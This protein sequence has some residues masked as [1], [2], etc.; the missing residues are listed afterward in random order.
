[1]SPLYLVGFNFKTPYKFLL[2]NQRANQC[3]DAEQ[4]DQHRH[5]TGDRCRQFGAPLAKRPEA[6]PL[7]SICEN[8]ADQSNGDH[9]EA[10][11]TGAHQRG[12]FAMLL[13]E[14][15]KNLCDG[16]SKRDQR[17]RCSHPGD[18]RPLVREKRALKKPVAPSDQIVRRIVLERLRYS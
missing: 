13:A 7:L 8:Q 11:R 9:N 2:S 5:H 15:L 4:R 12:G 6:A 1:M 17:Q 18:P 10:N 16:E 14:V 3:Q